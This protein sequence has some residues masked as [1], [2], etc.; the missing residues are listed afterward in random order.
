MDESRRLPYIWVF[1]SGVGAVGTK[2]KSHNRF[3]LG[4]HD[5]GVKVAKYVREAQA[6]EREEEEALDEQAVEEDMEKLRQK[7]RRAR[8]DLSVWGAPRA[9]AVM[10]GKGKVEA[11]EEDEEDRDD[12]AGELESDFEPEVQVTLL[13]IALSQAFADAQLGGDE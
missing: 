11:E 12:A 13:D 2:A 4:S 3:T 8:M 10:K 7:G 6:R 9:P 1:E 5:G